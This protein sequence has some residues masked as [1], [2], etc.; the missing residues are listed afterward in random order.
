MTLDEILELHMRK[1]SVACF[2]DPYTIAYIDGI[3]YVHGAEYSRPY[4]KEIFLLHNDDDYDGAL[5]PVGRCGIQKL[6]YDFSWAL[7]FDDNGYLSFFSEGEQSNGAS[8]NI[9]LL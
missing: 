2:Y 5:P 8:S 9:D 4:V 6:G 1:V 3:I 7:S